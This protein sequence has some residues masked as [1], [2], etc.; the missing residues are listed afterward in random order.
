MCAIITFVVILKRKGFTMRKKF[1]SILLIFSIFFTLFPAQNIYAATNDTELNIYA[2]YLPGSEK[3]DSVLLE[4]KGN[5]LLIDMGSSSHIATIIKQLQSIGANDI[6]IMFSHLHKDHIGAS[7][8]NLLAGLKQL[9]AADIHVNTLYLADPSL[10]PYSPN[11]QRRYLRIQNYISTLN[12]R[13]IVY[14]NVGDHINIGDADGQIIGPLNTSLFL[15]QKYAITPGSTLT[16]SGSSIYTYYENNCSLAAIFT[17]G[18]TR[19][20]TAGD[21]MSDEANYLLQRY[22][23]QLDCD[24]MKLSHHGIS[25]GNSTEL[26]RAISPTY[27]F[28]SNS[29]FTGMNEETGHWKTYASAT[30]ATKYGMCYFPATEK[31]TMIY[32][33]KNDIITLYQGTTVSSKNRV[34]KWISVFGEDGTRR[35]HNMYYFKNGKPLTGIQYIDKHYF[36]FDE[37]GRMEY[38]KFSQDTGAYLGWRTYAGGR[39]FFRFSSD[40]KY[41]YMAKGFTDIKGEKYYFRSNGFKMVN[42]TDDVLFKHIGSNY[43]ALTPQDTFLY[44]E[45]YE[46]VHPSDSSEETDSDNAYDSQ[47]DP[48]IDYTDDAEEKVDSY[49]F[50]V[51]G[52][53]ARNCIKEIDDEYYLFSDDGILVR[54]EGESEYKLVTFKNKNYAVYEDGT[55]LTD[56]METID[57]KKYYFD[58]HGIMQKSAMVQIDNHT[59]YFGKSGKLI[60]DCEI[61]WKGQKYY[62]KPSGVV[63]KIKSK[64]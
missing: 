64:K 16:E 5:Y 47:N 56:E 21:C 9:E 46:I 59:Y 37:T 17:C 14:L 13:H 36:Y 52:K 2:M 40:K 28:G 22:G 34:N 29:S 48:S 10:S 3:G 32:H 11:N 25:S 51:S 31:K 55:L 60:R 33:I 42:G 15:P 62:C 19:Y 39:R 41:A 12:N 58:A 35:D 61:K 26:L 44:D 20:F 27:S 4:S 1:L 24:I 30:R 50:D 6:D 7:S 54:P 53:M 43:Y 23:N 18:S 45:W 38:G 57:G 8:G 49:Y 63:K